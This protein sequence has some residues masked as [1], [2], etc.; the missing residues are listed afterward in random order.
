MTTSKKRFVFGCIVSPL[1]APLMALI[2]ILLVGEDVRGESYK[3]EYTLDVLVELLSIAGMF[4]VLGA[5]I[6]YA[7][8]IFLGLPFYFLAKR[9]GIINFWTVTTGSAF[10]AVLPLLVISAGIGFDLY[11]DAAKSSLAFYVAIALI[12]Y[13]V[14][15]TFWFA[16]GLY[17]RRHEPSGSG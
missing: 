5:P 12:G 17:E 13:S 2:I 14:G 11:N 10:V 4:L 8:T 16:S 15:L 9:L 6:A 7:V 3:F 1:V